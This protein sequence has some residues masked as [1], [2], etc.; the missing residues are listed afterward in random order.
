IGYAGGLTIAQRDGVVGA[1][2]YDFFLKAFENGIGVRSNGD[3]IAIAPILTSSRAE[4]DPIF[5]VLRKTA[6]EIS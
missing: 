3:S 5:D 1:R 6:N 4:L 2:A